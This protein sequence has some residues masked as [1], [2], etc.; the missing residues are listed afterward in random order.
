VRPHA[1]QRCAAMWFKKLSQV[2]T[3]LTV[4]VLFA[5]S[6]LVAPVV[7]KSE[8]HPAPPA[9]A[10][11]LLAEANRLSWL[12]NWT[13]AGPLYDRAEALFRIAGDK[14]N[15]IFAHLGRIRAFGPAGFGSAC[16]APCTSN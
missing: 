10:P 4:L 5:V 8:N 16:R 15:E 3:F 13:A 7:P 9:D 11:S 6:S 1:Q 14:R 12:E 2:L